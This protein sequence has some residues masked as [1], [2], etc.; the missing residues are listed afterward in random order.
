MRTV[1]LFVDS[2]VNMR[3]TWTHL[4][5]RRHW[6]EMQ[7]ALTEHTDRV[8]RER[9]HAR[10]LQTQ[11][12]LLQVVLGVLVE[13]VAALVDLVVQLQDLVLRLDARTTRRIRHR[14][15][16]RSQGELHH[17]AEDTHGYRN[18]RRLLCVKL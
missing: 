4:Q 10:R 5:H 6:R 12:L 15:V 1:F 9:R 2:I 7:L 16:R 18:K 17:V 13:M 8:V 3:Q 14:A 11:V